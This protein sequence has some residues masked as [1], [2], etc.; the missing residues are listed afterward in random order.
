[1]LSAIREKKVLDPEVE[2]KLRRALDEFK[3]VF[4]REVQTTAA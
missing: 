4:Q 1:V 2:E 3:E